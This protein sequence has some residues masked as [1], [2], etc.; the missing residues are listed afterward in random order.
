MGSYGSKIPDVELEQFASS[1]FF[2]KS[3]ISKLYNKF[4]ALGG[5]LSA[6]LDMEEMCKLAELRNNPFRYR[7]CEIFGHVTFKTIE[8]MVAD[9]EQKAVDP[10]HEGDEP[11][12]RRM[13]KETREV[14]NVVMTF[15][16]FLQM[17]NAFS[18]RASL[19]VKTYYAFKLYDFDG[20]RFIN[21]EDIVRALELM[22]GEKKMSQEKMHQVAAAVLVEGDLDGTNRL[23]QTEFI[24]IIK[25][26]PDFATKFQFTVEV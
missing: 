11:G 1:T 5:S 9:K 14:K 19:Q 24:R 20:D 25:R 17:L 4:E 26:I 21:T 16:N 23:S 13:V 8:V 18:P 3:E 15:N 22:V 7:M 10:D 12:E 6:P 2:T